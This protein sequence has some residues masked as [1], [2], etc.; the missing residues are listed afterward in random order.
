[1]PKAVTEQ[2]IEAA[3]KLRGQ[4]EFATALALT[5][6]MLNRAQDDGAR[7]RLLFDVLYC[8]T[9]LKADEVTNDAICEL[10]KLPDPK[11]SRIFIDHIQAMSYLA[12]GKAKEALDLIDANLSTQYMERDNFRDLKYEHLAYRGR[13]LAYLQRWQESLESLEAAHRMFPEGKRTT[14]ILIDKSLCMMMFNR[15]EEALHLA[16]EVR[17]RE[18]GDMETLAMQYMAEC[19]LGLRRASDA[20][21]LYSEIKKRLPCR[22]VQEERIQTGIT[23]AMAYLEKLRPQGKPS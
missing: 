14:D 8:S 9:R 21:K 10:E 7:M 17:Q 19:D 2:E 23:N 22:L 6:D 1:M 3:E 18:H 11:M 13:A 15:Y 16:S 5:Q 4:G 12:F 20:L